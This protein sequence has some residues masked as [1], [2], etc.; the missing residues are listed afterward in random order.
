MAHNPELDYEYREGREPQ[1]QKPIIYQAY[2]NQN[3]PYEAAV[4]ASTMAKGS[5]KSYLLKIC[6]GIAVL[7]VMGLFYN[8]F[9]GM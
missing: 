3:D 8:W 2:D 9:T 5:W 4:I 7:V 6:G 1:K